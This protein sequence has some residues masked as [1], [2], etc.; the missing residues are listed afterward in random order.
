MTGRW[1]SRDPIEEEGGVNFYNILTNDLVGRLDYLGMLFVD[2]GVEHVKT[3]QDASTLGTTET[4]MVL[5]TRCACNRDSNKWESQLMSFA[6]YSKIII[7]THLVGRKGSHRDGQY[8]YLQIP[9]KSLDRTLDHEKIHVGHIKKFHEKSAD[10]INNNFSGEFNSCEACQNNRIEKVEH[11]ES[12]WSAARRNEVDHTS[13]DFSK[14]S[15]GSLIN[16]DPGV[17]P[18]DLPDGY[19]GW[20]ADPYGYTNNRNIGYFRKHDDCK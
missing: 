3:Y 19:V 20:S 1:L 13:D 4:R 16:G 14:N 11:W 10:S 5:V 8:H 17:K 2:E 7:R 15:W 12:M 9:Q 18:S 6:I